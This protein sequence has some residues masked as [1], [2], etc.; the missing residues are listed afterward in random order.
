MAGLATA[1][2][3]LGGQEA[4]LGL[5]VEALRSTEASSH[6]FR[7]L[8]EESRDDYLT[9]LAQTL[10]DVAGIQLAAGMKSEVAASAREAVAMYEELAGATPAAFADRLAAARDRLRDVDR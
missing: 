8:A 9:E 2:A 6:L 10:H 7:I 4:K 5:T 3:N 1:L